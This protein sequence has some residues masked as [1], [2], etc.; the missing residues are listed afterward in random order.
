MCLQPCIP[1]SGNFSRFSTTIMRR[2]TYLGS[3]GDP[4]SC[5]N[6]RP[7]SSQMGI[8]KV[9]AILVRR[10]DVDLAV[11]RSAY[12]TSDRTAIRATMRVS[13]A[14]PHAAAVQKISLSA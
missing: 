12:F 13:F 10:N 5:E 4:S 14:F 9:R 6:T 8:P 2:V 3:T 1:I 11:D 7:L